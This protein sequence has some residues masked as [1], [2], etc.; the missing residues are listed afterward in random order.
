M[1]GRRARP[2]PGPQL[3]CADLEL[4]ATRPFLLPTGFRCMTSTQTPPAR[5][6]VPKSELPGQG[7]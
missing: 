7:M 5:G 6:V 1:W 2:L 3:H 4:S